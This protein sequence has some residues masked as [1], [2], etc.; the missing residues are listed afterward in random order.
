MRTRRPYPRAAANSAHPVHAPALAG[1]W[2]AVVEDVAEMAAAAP[3]MDFGPGHEQHPVIPC[4]HRIGDGPDEAGPPCAA[5]KLVLRPE[6]RQVAAR[7][8]IGTAAMLAIEGTGSG[9]LGALIAKHAKL[10]GGQSTTPLIGTEVD[11]IYLG[12]RRRGRLPKKPSRQ[13]LRWHR[14]HPASFDDRASCP[15]SPAISTRGAFRLKSFSLKWRRHRPSPRPP[16]DRLG[17]GRKSGERAGAD[18]LKKTRFA[19]LPAKIGASCPASSPHRLR[20]HDPAMNRGLAAGL[21]WPWLSSRRWHFSFDRSGF[22]SVA[23]RIEGAAGR[24]RRLLATRPL[25]VIA[26][27]SWPYILISAFPS[28]VRRS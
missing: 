5:F 16:P 2:R 15:I 10:P 23:R 18:S 21:L 7:A 8:F 25:L 4:A 14:Y 6:D 17:Y 26:T 9:P 3:A 19:S 11:L 20:T 28:R 13:R 1:R 27:F 12:R 24:S 22:L